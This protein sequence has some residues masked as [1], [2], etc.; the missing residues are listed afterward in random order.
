M[1]HS[2]ILWVL[3]NH[4][5]ATSPTTDIKI[6]IAWSSATLKEATQKEDL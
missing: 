5:E 2:A 3:Q 1:I 6:Y 4:V